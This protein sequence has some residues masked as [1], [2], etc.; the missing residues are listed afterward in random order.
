MTPPALI[1]VG[2][3]AAW[4]AHV[5]ALLNWLADRLDPEATPA[6]PPAVALR[7]ARLAGR[8]D[9][10]QLFLID[11]A[12]LPLATVLEQL[13]ILGE[14]VIPVLRREFDALRPAHVPDAAPQRPSTTPTNTGRGP[15]PVTHQQPTASEVPT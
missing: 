11:H 1:R 5:E 14:H 13:E 4:L 9:L 7:L 6:L 15:E 12:G 10:G 3:D 8:I 2:E